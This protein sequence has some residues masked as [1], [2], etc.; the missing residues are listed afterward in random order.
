MVDAA[1]S[2]LAV[3]Q[4]SQIWLQAALFRLYELTA[5]VTAA[6]GESEPRLLELLAALAGEVAPG[7]PE[8]VLWAA[9]YKCV[10]ARTAADCRLCL[11]S[12]AAR[13]LAVLA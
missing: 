11:H 5:L 2:K 4:Q 6:L 3:K 7:S 8:H 1:F 9:Q 12:F 13:L 10:P